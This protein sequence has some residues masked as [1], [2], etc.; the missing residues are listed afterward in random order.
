MP[1]RAVDPTQ[2]P[3][4]S[5]AVR[6]SGQTE[7]EKRRAAGRGRL[8]GRLC[9]AKA[10]SERVERKSIHFIGG[11]PRAGST[12]LGNILAQNP[13]FH[14]TPTSGVIEALLT[15]RTAFDQIAD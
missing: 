2:G 9:E 4:R 11:M 13:R 1:R 5:R 12:I 15:L 3:A 7:L 10:W 8:G 6:R 14:V